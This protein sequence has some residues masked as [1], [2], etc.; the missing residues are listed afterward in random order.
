MREI[1][2][3][4]LL[5][6][7]GIF[8]ASLFTFI[9]GFAGIPGALLSSAAAK[10]SVDGI[11]PIWGLYLTVAGQLYVSLVFVT[12]VINIVEACI[13]DSVGFGKWIAWVVAFFVAVAPSSIAL[14]DSA[15]A[16]HRTVQHH[17]TTI[18]TPLTVIGFF[19]FKMFPLIMNTG[20][21][22]LPKF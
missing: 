18:T 6:F 22:W 9:I 16:E 3:S 19:I 10:R 13:R 21:G 17:A 15:R 4:I 8:A 20:W 1:G 7:C 14:K 2:F 11:T 5:A 12:L